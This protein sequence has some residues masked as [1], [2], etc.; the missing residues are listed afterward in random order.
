MPQGQR[1]NPQADQLL[2]RIDSLGDRVRR[3]RDDLDAASQLE[4]LG[5]LTSAIAHEFN[6]IL[7]PILSY[8]RVALDSPED[9]DL[10]HRA[11]ER[12][13]MG[14]ERASRIASSVL[15]L[16]GNDKG[17]QPAE[18]CS[19]A[20]ALQGALACL[21]APLEA[22][23][24]ELRLGIAEELRL[25][26]SQT[27]LEHVFLNLLLNS[28]RALG[29]GG[30]VIEISCENPTI[31]STWNSTK[32]DSDTVTLVFRDNGPG[33]DAETLAGLF[34]PFQRTPSISRKQSNGLGL[35]ICRQLLEAAGGTIA[36]E[37]TDGTGATFL[38]TLPQAANQST[39]AQG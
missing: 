31:G 5:L 6:N 9:I 20:V 11:L 19:P 13:A 33:I 21:A 7:T 35:A 22:R 17:A 15:R 38:I 24:I 25:P 8:A 30:G 27:D 14:V 3:S 10:C 37:S 34:E 4:T 1:T 18:S 29:E 32:A 2:A 23:S 16:A 36:A 12:A 26:I 39:P 28:S